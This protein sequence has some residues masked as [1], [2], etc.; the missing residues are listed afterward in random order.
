MDVEQLITTELERMLPLPSGSQA[1][2]SDVVDRAGVG[3]RPRV[4][5]RGRSLRLTPR[6]LIAVAVALAIAGAA[7]FAAVVATT[8]SG[9]Q[10]PGPI[11]PPSLANG[12]VTAAGYAGGS[13]WALTTNGLVISANGAWHEVTPTSLTV[14]QLGDAYFA[15]ASAGWLIAYGHT[16][17]D[18]AESLLVYRTTD[19][20]ASW[21]KATVDANASLADG[22]GPSW[23]TFA[24]QMDG[25]LEVQTV[26]SSNFSNANLYRT[27]DGGE[28]WTPLRIPIAGAI[29]FPT[30]TNGFVSGGAGGM[31]LYTTHDGGTS[32][33]LVSLPGPSGQVYGPVFSSP[34]D[35]LVSVTRATGSGTAVAVYQTNDGGTT[36]TPAGSVV[37][38]HSRGQAA[39]PVAGLGIGWLAAIGPGGAFA[40]STAGSDQATTFNASGL[41]HG[42]LGAVDALEFRA[43]TQDG[44]ALF[45]GG[46]CEDIKSTCLEYQALYTTS[47]AG[48]TWTQLKP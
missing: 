42:K 2:W 25:W 33:A 31:E 21:S 1:D 7:A 40:R 23:I 35:G 34:S 6:V 16:Q 14:T 43:G 10:H 17:P 37:I 5:R 41:P 4:A 18:G 39:T 19:G 29:A 12:H 9:T 47:D 45:Q 22:H 48:S 8:A 13:V 28:S 30:P 38:A 3:R 20:G 24:N 15:D 46:A 11:V 26:S 32:W 44:L 27:T 36:W